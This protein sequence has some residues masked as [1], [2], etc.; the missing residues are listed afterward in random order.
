M[1]FRPGLS[2]NQTSQDIPRL[3]VV[4]GPWVVV[5][6]ALHQR[7]YIFYYERGHSA[8]HLS[9][10]LDSFDVNGCGTLSSLPRC[11][12]E[13]RL[14]RAR[15]SPFP[16]EMGSLQKCLLVVIFPFYWS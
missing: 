9:S 6:C 4:T 2:L 11:G 14:R 5:L 1:R 7:R 3:G 12:P 10:S 8:S 16:L 13:C 15:P